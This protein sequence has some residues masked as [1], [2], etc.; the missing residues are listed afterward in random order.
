M[1]RFTNKDWVGRKARCLR[2]LQNKARTNF[3]VKGEIVEVIGYDSY[4]K[5]M[6]K[7]DNGEAMWKVTFRDIELVEDPCHTL[8]SKVIAYVRQTTCLTDD[9]WVGVPEVAAAVG[10]TSA[11]V[12]SIM[13]RLCERGLGRWYINYERPILQREE[14]KG[15]RGGY[16][17]RISPD[18]KRTVTA[19]D[20]VMSDHDIV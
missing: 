9:V 4:L 6:I 2:N 12:S 19:L 17:Y 7:G 5:F 16:G 10:S 11:V 14:G 8:E 13:K 20:M 15:K 3:Y 1:P 18:Q